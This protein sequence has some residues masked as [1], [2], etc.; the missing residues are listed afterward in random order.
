MLIGNANYTGDFVQRTDWQSDKT[1]GW[2]KSFTV[3]NFGPRDYWYDGVFAHSVFVNDEYIDTG[4]VKKLMDYE[5]LIKSGYV[6][7][8]LKNVFTKL[9]SLNTLE[10]EIEGIPENF[11]DILFQGSDPE[12]NNTKWSISTAEINDDEKK[13]KIQGVQV[14]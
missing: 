3:E 1:S 14:E 8:N 9:I 13:Y 2:Q 10:C 5:Y 12:Y 4:N 11:D 7:D 6:R